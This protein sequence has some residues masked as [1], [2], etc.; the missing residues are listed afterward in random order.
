M[1]RVARGGLVVRCRCVRMDT[2]TQAR[3]GRTDGR[4]PTA[5]AHTSMIM[6]SLSL[7]LLFCMMSLH[8]G[9]V[10][11]VRQLCQW[12]HNWLLGRCWVA[13]VLGAA[14]VVWRPPARC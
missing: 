10:S 8:C 5:H 14:R 2:L 13:A 4:T 11:V 7:S 9:F 1:Q 3:K 12:A 6:Q